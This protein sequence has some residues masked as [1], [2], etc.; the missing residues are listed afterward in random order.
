MEPN[1]QIL[2][3][4]A[5]YLDISPSDYKR[6]QE[7]FNAV[8]NWLADGEYIS[9]TSPDIYLQGSFRLGTVVR[10]YRGDEDGDFDIDQVCELS[11]P[12]TNR[13]PELLKRDIGDR[14]KDNADYQR[15][16]DD[17]GKRCWT[18]EYASEDGRPGFHL[19]ILPSLPSEKGNQFQI[20]ITDKQNDTYL[21]S[22]SNPKGYY[23][24]FKSKN[25][26]SQ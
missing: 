12:R 23:Y 9:G 21:W 8:R 15:M 2:A 19:D 13:N 6:A 3:Q 11:I 4:I 16:L 20:D 5:Q 22:P 24:W 25:P 1:E 18:L 14:L 17:E 26:Y 7:R 10:P